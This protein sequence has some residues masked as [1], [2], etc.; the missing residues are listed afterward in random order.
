MEKTGRNAL[1]PCGSG[2]KYK[3]C[4]LIG[5]PKKKPDFQGTDDVGENLNF[6]YEKPP[7]NHQPTKYFE[8]IADKI[9]SAKKTADTL[10]K[11]LNHHGLEG[12]IREL[13]LKECIEP[14]LTHSFCCGTGKLIDSYQNISDQID[15]VIY[16][17]KSV[18]PI[19]V[20]SDLG[21]YPLESVRYTF[22][23]KSKLTATGVR[24]SLKKFKSIRKLSSNP[25]KQ[26]NGAV[27]DIG[28]PTNVLFAFDSDISGS[29]IERYLKYDSKE[30]RICSVLCVIGKG[31]WSF[32]GKNLWY[33]FESKD[34]PTQ[35]A[36][37]CSFI[38]GFMNSLA[39]EES[40]FPLFMP[41][42][43]VKANDG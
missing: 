9:A 43:Y 42:V 39:I 4:C 16:H 33:G 22:E 3:K 41:G 34:H 38:T 26:P 21:L 1:C 36:E 17:R 40:Q 15:L 6:S 10:S 2:K 24:D 32:G 18:P 30:P 13:A 11:N 8:Y 12:Q 14:F 7:S 25:Q 28:K 31:Y 29:E 20:N 35:Y 5:H 19:L 37:F 27:K 23:V